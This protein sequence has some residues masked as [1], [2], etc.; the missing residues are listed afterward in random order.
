MTNDNGPHRDFLTDGANK[1]RLLRAL[2]LLRIVTRKQSRLASY[3]GVTDRTVRHALEGKAT[4]IKLAHI[5]RGMRQ[6]MED[7][8]EE[9]DKYEWSALQHILRAIDPSADILHIKPRGDFMA[10]VKDH[11]QL[12]VEQ[13]LSYTLWHFVRQGVDKEY[14]RLAIRRNIAKHPLL[15]YRVIDDQVAK[16]KDDAINKD[17]KWV[18]DEQWREMY[19]A[20]TKAKDKTV[21]VPME[22]I[23][24]EARPMIEKAAKGVLGVQAKKKLVETTTA[25]VQ[26]DRKRKAKAVKKDP[27]PEPTVFDKIE[28]QGVSDKVKDR[29]AKL[30]AMNT[31]P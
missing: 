31:G 8:R 12:T 10:K 24:S 30:L 2:H 13:S 23:K 14:V 17:Q 3:L 11:L 5:Q 1:H 15:A 20:A 21:A 28:E 18:T 4:E 25:A 22:R 16:A 19:L 9:V 29:V 7:W 27:A 6:Y 26:A